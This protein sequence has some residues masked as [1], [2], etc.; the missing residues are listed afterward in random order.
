M[1]S[2]VIAV[3]RKVIRGRLAPTRPRFGIKCLLWIISLSVIT[4]PR[5]SR[6]QSRI[7]LFA[8]LGVMIMM[9]VILPRIMLP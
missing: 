5:V 6:S 4:G 8:R 1:M 9:E 3:M 2:A 7:A